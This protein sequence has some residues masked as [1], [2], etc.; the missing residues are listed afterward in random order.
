MVYKFAY[1]EAIAESSTENR[2][3]ERTLL[4]QSIE[5]MKLAESAGLQSR[6]S[7]EAT[8]FVTRLWCHFIEDLGRPENSLPTELRAKLISIGL[9]LI[10]AAEEVRVGE[11]RSFTGMIEI[12]STISEGLK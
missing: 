1:S 6:Q 10:K 4:L 11:R 3:S 2:E 9:F 8:H 12:T 5:M 7:I